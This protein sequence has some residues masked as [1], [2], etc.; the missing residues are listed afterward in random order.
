MRR[1]AHEERI[2]SIHCRELIEAVSNTS[3][4]MSDGGEALRTRHD[5]ALLRHGPLVTYGG[6]ESR[7]IGQVRALWAFQ[8][9][10]MIERVHGKEEQAGPRRPRGGSPG[11]IGEVGP[12]QNAACRRVPL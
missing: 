2:F 1:R 7:A 10:E 4:K 9:N 12:G 5:A 11:A 8:E 3:V 6:R